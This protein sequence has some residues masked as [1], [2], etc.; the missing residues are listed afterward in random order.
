MVLTTEVTFP[1]NKVTFYGNLAKNF[2]CIQYLS[3]IAICLSLGVTS[4]TSPSISKD[5]RGT[6]IKERKYSGATIRR[7]RNFI[8]LII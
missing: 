3:F 5:W 4:V 2:F 1:V 8:S 7:V 6:C